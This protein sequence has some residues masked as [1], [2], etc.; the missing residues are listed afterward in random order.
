M[1]ITTNTLREQT[2]REHQRLHGVKLLKE[3]MTFMLDSYVRL[4]E[5]GHLTREE[6]NAKYFALA[7]LHGDMK[8][9]P[10]RE[11]LRATPEQIKAELDAWASAVQS[12]A[13]YQ[14]QHQIARLRA[15]VLVLKSFII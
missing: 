7:T 10:I 1:Q 9:E 3:R 13:S 8:G 6:A 2:K 15:E 11:N 4:I 5:E 12:N 14:N